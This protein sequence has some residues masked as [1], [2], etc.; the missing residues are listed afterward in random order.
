MSKKCAFDQEG[1]MRVSFP[2]NP[3]P[4]MGF[5]VRGLSFRS[6]WPRTRCAAECTG[7]ARRF[8]ARTSPQATSISCLT[9]SFYLLYWPRNLW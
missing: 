2:A 3:L 8:V 9:P 6:T 4:I 1:L 5:T 7:F